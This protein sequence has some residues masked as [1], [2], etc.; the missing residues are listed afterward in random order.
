[1]RLLQNPMVNSLRLGRNCLQ[2]DGLISTLTQGDTSTQLA[3]HDWWG[4][5]PMWMWSWGRLQRRRGW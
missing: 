4:Y 1:L 2:V 5:P 3:E